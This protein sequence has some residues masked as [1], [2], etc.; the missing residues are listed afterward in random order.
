LPD[1]W[2]YI[3]YAKCL[4]I[5]YN[6]GD[7]TFYNAINYVK[8]ALSEKELKKFNQTIALFKKYSRQYNFDW[9]MI[10]ALSYQ[11]SGIDQTKVSHVGAIG[12]MQVM[13]STAKGK[14]VNIPDIDKIESNI[15]AGTKYLRFM[16]DRYYADE[17]MDS[18]NKVLFTFASY[19]AGPAR[20]AKLRKE[21]EAMGL[22][23]NKWFGNVE[24]VAAKRIGRETV[25]YV[26]NIYKYYISYK[27]I[28][29]VQK[30]KEN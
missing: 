5:T 20:V 8:N 14:N 22:D 30:S 3:W 18:L 19:N 11:E 25:Q 24:I 23:P 4:S 15:H 29:E 21:A 6:E 12:A 26:S 9:L 10:A 1:T 28:S 13:P 7:R 27:L 17:K 16:V 2:P